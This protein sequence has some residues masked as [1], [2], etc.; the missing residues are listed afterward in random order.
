M[1]GRS[2]TILPLAGRVR[3]GMEK[4]FIMFF[5][6]NVWVVSPLAGE[7]KR[8]IEIKFILHKIIA[9]SQGKNLSLPLLPDW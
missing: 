1:R 2:S 5:E 6:E 7:M 3:G 8:G 9:I 4:K